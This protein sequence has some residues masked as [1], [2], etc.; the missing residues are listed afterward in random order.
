[1]SYLVYR[2]LPHDY[3]RYRTH[4]LSLDK[5]S[6]HLRFGYSINDAMINFLCDK[7]EKNPH[8]HKLFVVENDDLEVVGVGHI[9]LEGTEVELAFSVLKEYQGRGIGSTLMKRCVEWCQNRGI[10]TGCMVCLN[11]NQAVKNMARKHGVLIEEHGEVM[12]DIII[13][14]ANPISVMSEMVESNLA[15]FDHLGKIQRKFAKMITFPLRF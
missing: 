5:E 7:F 8:V 4:L 13:P 6:R 10:K 3:S 11:T 1:M 2:L 9:S 12:A 15:K 14:S